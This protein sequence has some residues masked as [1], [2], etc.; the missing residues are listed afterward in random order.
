VQESAREQLKGLADR[1]GERALGLAVRGFVHELRNCINP[2]GLQLAILQR[3]VF[4]PIEGLGEVLDGLRES[5]A[6]AHA[7]LDL[8]AKLADEVAPPHDAD[9]D[10]DRQLW[11]QLFESARA[12]EGDDTTGN[13]ISKVVPT[14][15]SDS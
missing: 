11:N 12:P 15:S 5:V 9:N 4:T 10:S 3:R 14:P 7:A 6:R 8:A 13:T 1:D 2:M